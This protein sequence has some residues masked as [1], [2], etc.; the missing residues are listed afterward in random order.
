MTKRKAILWQ[1]IF[2]RQVFSKKFSE[3]HKGFYKPERK[4]RKIKYKKL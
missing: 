4:I 3:K 2:R 1:K